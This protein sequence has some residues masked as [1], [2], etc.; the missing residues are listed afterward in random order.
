M[1]NRYIILF[2]LVLV[3]NPIMGKSQK[4]FISLDVLNK[5]FFSLNY[6]YSLHHKDTSK[7]ELRLVLGC[8]FVPEMNYYFVAT[9]FKIKPLRA[10]SRFVLETGIFNVF[11]S[12]YHDKDFQKSALRND[13]QFYEQVL[14]RPLYRPSAY[15]GCG[16]TFI[17]R[18]TIELTPFVSGLF[19][20]HRKY[21]NY[22]EFLPWIGVNFTFGL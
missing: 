22:I 17:R 15:F 20:W 18:R 21:H 14:Y 10:S 6:E 1:K 4:H 3:F 13:P 2:A 8:G 12:D 11:D 19:F 16:Y 9:T 5:Y 7:R